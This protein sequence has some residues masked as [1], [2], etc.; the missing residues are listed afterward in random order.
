MDHCNTLA[1]Q[2][3]HQCGNLNQHWVLIWY[4]MLVLPFS[5]L[6]KHPMGGAGMWGVQGGYMYEY[7]V[8]QRQNTAELCHPLWVPAFQLWGSRGKCCLVAAASFPA[9]RQPDSLSSLLHVRDQTSAQAHSLPCSPD[10]CEVAWGWHRNICLA[11]SGESLQLAQN[12][13]RAGTAPAK[14]EEDVNLLAI[15]AV[16]VSRQMKLI[17][18]GRNVTLSKVLTSKS[19]YL[20]RCAGSC[21]LLGIAMF[22]DQFMP[23]TAPAAAW[24]ASSPGRGQGLWHRGRRAKP[25]CPGRGKFGTWGVSPSAQLS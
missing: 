20:H 21:Q 15:F 13:P 10:C 23:P 7:T 2:L 16:C 18:K 3:L 9:E 11:S 8:L 19:K 12:C 1:R 6:L 4:L 22:L 24:E 14:S 5:G 25:G 17:N